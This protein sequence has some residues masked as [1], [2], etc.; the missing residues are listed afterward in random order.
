MAA[1]P[2][3]P[4]EGPKLGQGQHAGP[5]AE[6][7]DDSWLDDDDDDDVW[8]SMDDRPVQVD[9][10]L[11]IG[12]MAAEHNY[13]GLKAAGITHVLQVAEGMVPSH[14]SEGLRYRTVQVADC[15]SEDLVAHFG[16]C[17]DFIAEAHGQGGGVLVHCV[18][19]VSRSATVC[20]GWLMFRHRLTVDEAFKRVHR[21][22]PWVAPNPGFRKQLERFYE[23]GCDPT[24]WTAWRHV[25]REEPLTL[26]LQSLQRA[27]EGG[28]RD[29]GGGGGP[30][31]NGE[32]LPSL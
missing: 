12:S 8:E 30:L 31:A 21:V 20:M 6:E 9:D 2:Q 14:S 25:W 23:L 10:K 19:G 17:F 27:A 13:D 29:S 11:F 26:V 28:G 18:A 5:C 3:E 16:R 4:A 15:P 7:S 22:R 24:R 32:P 1:Q